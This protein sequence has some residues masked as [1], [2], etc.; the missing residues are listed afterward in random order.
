MSSLNY[1]WSAGSQGIDNVSDA[2]EMVDALKAQIE[3]LVSRARL[4]HQAYLFAC[5]ILHPDI[6][7]I[8]YF[9]Q[10]M[11]EIMLEEDKLRDEKRDLEMR[12]SSYEADQGQ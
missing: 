10:E 1:C 11:E 3:V 7:E 12:I 8:K 9:Q 5:G 6:N 2:R 4:A